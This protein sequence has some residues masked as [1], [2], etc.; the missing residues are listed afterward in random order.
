MMLA[1][2][3]NDVNVGA[4]NKAPSLGSGLAGSCKYPNVH[5]VVLFVVCCLWL[6]LPFSWFALPRMFIAVCSLPAFHLA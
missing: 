6:V 4:A 3:A 5:C 2:N 1:A